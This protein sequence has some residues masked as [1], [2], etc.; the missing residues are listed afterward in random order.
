MACRYYDEIITRKIQ[1]WIPEEAHLRVLKPDETKRLFELHA[2]DTNDAPLQLPIIALSRSNDI[3][4]LSTVKTTKSFDGLIIAPEYT[5]RD[6]SQLRGNDYQQAITNIPGQVK[7]FNVLPI[8]LMYQLDIYTKTVDEGDEYLRS[9]LFKLINNPAIYIDIPYANTGLRHVANI[10]V[11]P[12]VSDTSAITERLFTGQF[13][14]WTIQFE[15]QDAY[16]FS[17]PYRDTWRLVTVEDGV[18]IEL[19]DNIAVERPIQVTTYLPESQLATGYDWSE[20][21][22]EDLDSSQKKY[23]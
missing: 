1:R 8:K 23:L 6:V 19:R 12:T 21:D 20:A 5:T 3:E 15:I 4:L 16:L 2:S 22:L 11:S 13:T 10:R 18:E 17:I 9:F 7:Q 14:R